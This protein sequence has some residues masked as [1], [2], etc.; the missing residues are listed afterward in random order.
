MTGGHVYPGL[1]ET[2]PEKEKPPLPIYTNAA[3]MESSDPPP[4]GN[5]QR[6]KGVLACNRHMLENQLACDITFVVGGNQE[7]VG[8]HRYVLQSRSG[9]FFA[10][11]DGPGAGR[12]QVDL[13]DTQPKVLWQLLRYMYYEELYP[14]SDTVFQL[15]ALA[16]K[17]DVATAINICLRFLHGCLTVSTACDILETAHQHDDQE[18]DKDCML[19]IRKHGEDVIQTEGMDRL[20]RECLNRVLTMEGLEISPVVRQEVTDRWARQQCEDK[21][22]EPTEDNKRESLGDVLYVTRDEKKSHRFI[23]D[24]VTDR[25]LSGEDETDAPPPLYSELS[26]ESGEDVPDNVSMTSASSAGSRR[27]LRS[28]YSRQHSAATWPELNHITRFKEVSG[29]VEND[30]TADAIA[31]TVD[32]NIYLYGFGIYGSKKQGEASFKVDT[33]VTRKKVDILMESITIKGAGV[34][35][36]VMFQKP[37]KVQKGK[38]YTLEIYVQGPTSLCGADG[39]GTVTDGN[40][41]FKFTKTTA[42][43]GNRTTEQNGQIP[44]VYFLPY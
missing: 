20:C 17:Y 25:Q 38:P 26:M 30:G 19:F 16:D 11:L 24:S 33:V 31:F 23:L 27:T 15:L 14:D 37:I 5:W 12:S 4:T 8:A 9:V 36:P 35:L 44:R 41:T 43:K 3:S 29:T 22:C 7:R 40:T 21:K 42:V 18:L 28:Q 1:E 10:M 32:S 6:A 13:P 39:M 2:T 34:I